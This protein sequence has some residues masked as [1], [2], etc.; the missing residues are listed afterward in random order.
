VLGEWSP[1]YLVAYLVISYHMTNVK[2]KGVVST[3]LH[4]R[5]GLGLDS[6]LCV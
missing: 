2:A 1:M 3:L 5:L 6:Y 4:F